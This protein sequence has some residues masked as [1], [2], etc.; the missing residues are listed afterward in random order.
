MTHQLLIGGIPIPPHAGISSQR[1]EPLG[2]STLLRMAS[3]AGKKRTHWNKLKTTIS[4]SG[5]LPLALQSLDFSS[6]IQIACIQPRSL[7]SPTS[8]V[9]ALPSN[10]RTDVAPWG[11]A[12]VGHEWVEV[13]L[14][15]QGDQATLSEVTGAS[16]YQVNWL[17]LLTV[18]MEDPSSEMNLDGA[19]YNW[20][21]DAEEA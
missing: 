10:R 12:L 15:L 17:P 5:W 11:W 13:S 9:F 14:V 1:Y 21:I 3:G 18:Y 8:R 7:G 4:G 20:T 2:G 16:L 6:P 19:T